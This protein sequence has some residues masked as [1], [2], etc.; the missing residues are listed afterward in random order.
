MGL[1]VT[2]AAAPAVTLL[3]SLLA[4]N[5]G[6]CFTTDSLMFG[7]H[8]GIKW[9]VFEKYRGDFWQSIRKSEPAPPDSPHASDCSSDGSIA[10]P[11]S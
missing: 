3:A 4:I 1:F 7:L 9:H 8:K 2:F 10:F 6:N 11:I 5:I